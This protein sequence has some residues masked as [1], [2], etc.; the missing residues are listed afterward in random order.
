VVLKPV[1]YEADSDVV[2]SGEVMVFV[3]DSFVVTVRH[4]EEAPAGGRTAPSGGGAGDAAARAHGGAVLDRRRRVDHYVDVAGELQTDLEELEA[5]VFSP[6][7]GGSRTTASRIY[8]FKRQILEFRRATG[9]LAQP[10]ARLAGV[11]RRRPGC[12]S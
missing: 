10:L 8:T 5:A 3:G 1:G 6:T 7:G 11:G 12:R 2:T 4:G 9:P